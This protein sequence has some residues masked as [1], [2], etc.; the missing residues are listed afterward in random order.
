M[1][2]GFTLT[3]RDARIARSALLVTAVRTLQTR[4][5]RVVQGIIAQ[6]EDQKGAISAPVGTRVVSLR[7][8]L[9]SAVLDLMR[10][11]GVLSVRFVLLDSTVRTLGLLQVQLRVV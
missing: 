7:H 8:P 5:H 3:S 2:K 10:R 9:W 11:M 6:L 4:R 1:V